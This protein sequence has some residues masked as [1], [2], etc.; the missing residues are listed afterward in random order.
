MKIKTIDINAKEWFDSISLGDF[1]D[2]IEVNGKSI[3]D[4]ISGY[5]CEEVK[6]EEKKCPH[7]QHTTPEDIFYNEDL[8]FT[9]EFLAEKGIEFK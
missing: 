4:R 1:I 2:N 8:H 9:K 6:I 3:E 7:C 5:L